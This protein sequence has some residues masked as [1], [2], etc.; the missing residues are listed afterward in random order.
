[1][2]LLGSL[3]EMAGLLAVLFRR[4]NWGE[5]PFLAEGKNKEFSSEWAPLRIQPG[6]SVYPGHTCTAYVRLTAAERMNHSA[7]RF[8]EEL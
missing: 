4:E 5:V 2:E 3:S 1:M 6:C 8:S 7:W